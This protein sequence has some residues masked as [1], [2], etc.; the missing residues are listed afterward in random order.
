MSMTSSGPI[1][2]APLIRKPVVRALGASAVLGPLA[3]AV[4]GPGTVPPLLEPFVLL[5]EA[6]GVGASAVRGPLAGAVDGPGTVPPLLEPFVLLLE[7]TGGRV[8][9][10]WPTRGSFDDP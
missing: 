3:G 9:L 1:S 7:A 6:P 2:Y 4:D 8:T 10:A 5:L